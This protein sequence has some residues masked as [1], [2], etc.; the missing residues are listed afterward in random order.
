MFASAIRLLTLLVFAFLVC[1]A[2][3]PVLAAEP[4][5]SCLIEIADVEKSADLAALLKAKGY[6]TVIPAKNMWVQNQQSNSAVW[7]GKKVPLDVLRAVLPEAI[8]YNQYLRFFHVVG[9]RGE[10]PPEQVDRTIHIGGH[11]EAALVKKLNPID[12]QELLAQL[13]KVATIEEL[14][15]YLHEKNTPKPEADKPGS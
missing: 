10:I 12:Q 13:A 7:I 3:Q 1:R 5:P 14:H 4:A 8:R 15:G 6:Q 11:I 2:G 9:D